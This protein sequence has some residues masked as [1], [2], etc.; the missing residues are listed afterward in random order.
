[1]AGPTG[2]I[3]HRPAAG[4]A[5]DTAAPAF[6]ARP[7]RPTERR[8]ACA[9]LCDRGNQATASFYDRKPRAQLSA[10]RQSWPRWGGLLGRGGTVT[11][12]SAFVYAKCPRAGKNTLDPGSKPISDRVQ[13][14][15]PA[16]HGSDGLRRP[17]FAAGDGP[18]QPCALRLDGARDGAERV[19]NLVGRGTL[20][21][22]SADR[23]RGNETLSDLPETAQI[24]GRLGSS[25]GTQVRHPVHRGCRE[26]ALTSPGGRR[27]QYPAGGCM[28]RPGSQNRGRTAMVRA[29]RGA[30][31]SACVRASRQ[32][33]GAR[34]LGIPPR[35][36]RTRFAARYSDPF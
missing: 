8:I 2:G 16:G 28:E 22:L 23:G 5:A 13:G 36:P 3:R 25:A 29:G 34:G 31:D 30:H 19:R 33:R 10:Q 15:A 26:Q 9:T 1:M 12:R 32:A 11:T 18:D 17:N 6:G 7:G 14:R 20:R 24:A 27:G 35:H 4:P 21:R